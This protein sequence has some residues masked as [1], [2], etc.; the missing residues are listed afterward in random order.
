MLKRQ[1]FRGSDPTTPNPQG[2]RDTRLTYALKNQSV[3]L[4]AWN[5]KIQINTKFNIKNGAVLRSTVNVK[6][7]EKI[8]DED[9]FKVQ[10][11]VPKQLRGYW[12]E[13]KRIHDDTVKQV[14]NAYL[15]KGYQLINDTN[16]DDNNP[17]NETSYHQF[18]TICSMEV[19]VNET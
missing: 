19:P 5:G 18:S 6:N 17:D 7:I 13:E 15:D 3:P 9:I 4:P 16:S 14:K 1:H 8:P 2:K 11:N 12:L 10:T